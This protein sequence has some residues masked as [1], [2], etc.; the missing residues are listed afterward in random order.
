MS[1]KSFPWNKNDEKNP[2]TALNKETPQYVAP[3]LF[4]PCKLERKASKRPTFTRP[5]GVKL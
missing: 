5:T 1:S 2:R 4:T 3:T